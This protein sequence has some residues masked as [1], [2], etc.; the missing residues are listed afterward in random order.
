[1]I[2]SIRLS[3][4]RWRE[5]SCAEVL[6]SQPVLGLRERRL[7]I[8]SYACCNQRLDLRAHHDAIKLLIG[9][10]RRIKH[11]MNVLRAKALQDRSFPVTL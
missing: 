3:H 5:T 6:V 7:R 8:S 4:Q 1:V 9:V 10:E 2:N 11:G